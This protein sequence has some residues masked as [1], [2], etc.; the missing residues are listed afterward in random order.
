[1]SNPSGCGSGRR[2]DDM[3][4]RVI[5]WCAGAGML[6]LIGLNTLNVVDLIREDER[7]RIMASWECPKGTAYSVTYLDGSRKCQ[8]YWRKG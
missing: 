1:M 5:G 7:K 8:L 2:W 4:D 6:V 3:G